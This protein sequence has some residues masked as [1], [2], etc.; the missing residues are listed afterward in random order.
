MAIF[1]ENVVWLA[2]FLNRG[3]GQEI[4]GIS[5]KQIGRNLVYTSATGLLIE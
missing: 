2:G 5:R 3:M 4:V 1:G